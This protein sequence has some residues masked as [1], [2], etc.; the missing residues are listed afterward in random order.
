MYDRHTG[1]GSKTCRMTCK[2]LSAG[3]R[4]AKSFSFSRFT[5]L[6]LLIRVYCV[7]CLLGGWVFLATRAGNRLAHGSRMPSQALAAWTRWA[8]APFPFSRFATQRLSRA[9]PPLCGLFAM[10]VLRRKVLSTPEIW[11]RCA[12]A[13]SRRSDG[14]TASEVVFHWGLPEVLSVPHRQ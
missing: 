1:P 2:A 14:G 12:L 7:G 9:N 8:C 3:H 11:K 4:W 10:F 6:G 13:I 5:Q